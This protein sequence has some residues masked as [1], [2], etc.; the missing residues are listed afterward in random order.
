MYN[1]VSIFYLLF[2]FSVLLFILINILTQIW[3]FY[4]D[5]I[6]LRH[7]VIL[8]NQVHNHNNVEDIINQINT[9]FIYK[10]WYIIFLR[11]LHDNYITYYLS[12][13]EQ[14]KISRS[15]YKKINLN[16]FSKIH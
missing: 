1:Y 4:D 14:N 9:L 6:F 12:I 16:L 8:N 13:E 10:L 3:K 15:I 11:Y 2:I 7:I 5:Q